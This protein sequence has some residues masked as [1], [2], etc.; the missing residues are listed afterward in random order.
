MSFA[1]CNDKIYDKINEDKNMYNLYNLFFG[2][3]EQEIVKT[4]KEDFEKLSFDEKLALRIG[5]NLNLTGGKVISSEEKNINVDSVRLEEFIKKH[6]EN[7]LKMIEE[8]STAILFKTFEFDGGKTIKVG[9]SEKDNA[10]PTIQVTDNEEL[11]KTYWWYNEKNDLKFGRDDKS[12]EE[13]S[14]V[15]TEI[16]QELASDIV[17]TSIAE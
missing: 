9:I 14:P 1:Y 13:Y 11:N 2:P 8:K 15:Y 5:E 10:V 7:F 16:A 4:K 12:F 3:S 6:N 17:D